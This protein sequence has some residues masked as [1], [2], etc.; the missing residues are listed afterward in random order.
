[1][2]VVSFL[3]QILIKFQS[4]EHY[5]TECDIQ[6]SILLSSG[7]LLNLSSL[8][9]WKGSYLQIRKKDHI[10]YLCLMHLPSYV[11]INRYYISC[12]NQN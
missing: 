12:R 4:G 5:M 6:V 10:G 9:Y 1:M 8:L 3:H 11:V 7:F 2:F